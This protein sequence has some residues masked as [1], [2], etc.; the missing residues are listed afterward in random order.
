[1]VTVV[2]APTA[3]S[4]VTTDSTS[5]GN[6]TRSVFDEVYEQ[7]YFM[8]LHTAIN[9]PKRRVFVE[10]TEN[11]KLAAIGQHSSAVFGEQQKRE[12]RIRLGLRSSQ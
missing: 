5:T 9:S 11:E 1:V 2:S 7:Y 12:T 3:N 4:D 10:E 8:M 6:S